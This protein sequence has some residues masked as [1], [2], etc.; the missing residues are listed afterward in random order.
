MTKLHLI[1]SSEQA[2]A[3]ILAYQKAVNRP[4][5]QESMSYAIA[6]YGHDHE[7]LG[8]IFAPLKFVG[9]EHNS[10]E[11]YGESHDGTDGRQMENLLREWFVEVDPSSP[12]GQSRHLALRRFLAR[13]GKVPNKRARISVSK[14]MRMTDKAERSATLVPDPQAELW[15]ITSNPAIL[16]GKPCIRGMRIRVLDILEMLA[17]GATRDVILSDFPYLQNE[18]ITAALAYSMR[19]VDFRVVKAA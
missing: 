13:F 19:A 11:A 16:G 17:Y 9:Y 7:Q 5:M 14:D 4:E 8:L 3:N 18:D 1:T 10:A 15:R 6:W 12:L 2:I